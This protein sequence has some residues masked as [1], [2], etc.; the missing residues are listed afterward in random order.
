MEMLKAFA[1]TSLQGYTITKCVNASL[2][3]TVIRRHDTYTPAQHKWIMCRISVKKTQ[4]VSE[5]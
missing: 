5:H 2:V 3:L 1:K 4:R